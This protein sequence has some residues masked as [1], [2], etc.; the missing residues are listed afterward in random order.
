MLIFYTQPLITK[1]ILRNCSNELEWYQVFSMQVFPHEGTSGRTG[2]FFVVPQK[3]GEEMGW[4]ILYP[5]LK[6]Y[7]VPRQ[8]EWPNELAG[9]LLSLLYAEVSRGP[10]SQPPLFFFLAPFYFFF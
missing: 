2:Q 1:S 9:F 8:I 4:G 5:G 3:P 10:Y 6:S 7:V